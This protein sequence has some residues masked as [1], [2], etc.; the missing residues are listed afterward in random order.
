MVAPKRKNKEA[1]AALRKYLRDCLETLCNHHLYRSEE[2][3]SILHEHLRLMVQK[4]RKNGDFYTR[5]WTK[6]IAPKNLF[7]ILFGNPTNLTKDL[8]YK[9]VN[10]NKSIEKDMKFGKK[11]ADRIK[12]KMR[13]V[14]RGNKENL[15]SLSHI[16]KKK[17]NTK[18]KENK[19]KKLINRWKKA[20]R[21]KYYQQLQKLQSSKIKQRTIATKIKDNQIKICALYSPFA[22]RSR[23]C[24]CF[25]FRFCDKQSISKAFCRN[26][27]INNN[28]THIYGV[29][30]NKQKMMKRLRRSN[31]LRN[32]IIHNYGIIM[33]RH[34]TMH[35]NFDISKY[36]WDPGG[37]IVQLLST[38]C[39]Q[40]FS[41]SVYNRV[42]RSSFGS[43][44]KFG[45]KT[46]SKAYFSW[47]LNLVFTLGLLLV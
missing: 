20:S 30:M 34:Q 39:S 31:L 38:T 44:K 36:I 1:P 2:N 4:S 42:W 33:H 23:F 41:L 37:I 46:S 43:Q 47:T 24:F 17:K 35:G 8:K 29:G 7:K 5:E 16:F 9:M 12:E 26:I 14:K 32:K 25:F 19:K 40:H 22:S 15:F 6:E 45:R 21:Q 13:M 11:L 18:K 3:W 27:M 28:L 10:L